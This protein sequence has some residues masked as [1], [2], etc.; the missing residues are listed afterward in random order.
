MSTGSPPIGTSTTP[1]SE[2]VMELAKF[3]QNIQQHCVRCAKT[4]E[5]KLTFKNFSPL[6]FAENIRLQ[7]TRHRMQYNQTMK[8]EK[9]Q[10]V[11]HL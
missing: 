3:L 8:A 9:A 4:H 6:T 10:M 11:L 1:S 2:H 7:Q 5:E